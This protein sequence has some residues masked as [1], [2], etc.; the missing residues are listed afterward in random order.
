M[1][2]SAR[3]IHPASLPVQQE[4]SRKMNCACTI[5]C[6]TRLKCSACKYVNSLFKPP[7]QPLARGQFG[8]VDCFGQPLI[9][10]AVLFSQ[11]VRDAQE[12]QNL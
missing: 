4:Q 6:H 11:V 1:G 10:L 9:V 8:L 12:C 5:Y 3:N 7:S 2:E